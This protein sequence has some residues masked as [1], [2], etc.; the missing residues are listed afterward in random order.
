[1]NL[2]TLLAPLRS[3]PCGRPHFLPP[4][5]VEIGPG[6]LARTADILS[7]HGFPRALLAVADKNTLRAS[8]GILEILAAGGFACTLQLYDDLRVADMRDVKALLPMCEGVG[9]VLSIGSGSLNDICRLAAFRAGKPFA[10]F[11]TA[12]SM[13]GFA[14]DTAPITQR[15]FKTSVPCRA[16]SVIIGDTEV[17]AAA[18][19]VLKS[20]GFGDMLAKYVALVDWRVAQLTV[21]EYLCPQIVSLVEDAL[22]RVTSMAHRV[23]ANDPETAGAIMEALVMTGLAMT[24]AGCTRPASGCEHMISHFWEIKKL[25]RGELSDFHGRKVAVA[26]LLAAE[27]YHA[28]ASVEAMGFHADATDWDAVYAAYGP[29][30]ARD[31][32]ACNTP[33]VTDETTPAL[34]RERWP[35]I[36]KIVREGLPSSAELLALL[37]AAGAPT[38]P[39]EIGV[40]PELAAAGLA[41]H[42]YLRHR[43]TLSR[44]RGMMREATFFAAGNVY[45]PPPCANYP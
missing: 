21:G 5:A 19:A 35:E 16:P 32:R 11:A 43:M 2:Q 20:A 40:A 17:L 27:L 12:P 41:F 3:C 30:F 13:D 22:R 9:G 1:M 4:M 23:T 15:N 42:P 37:R 18:P 38:A 6:L 7:S 44:L 28:L 39:A 24:L 29:N 31:V 45:S 34:L 10:I 8:E 26:T 36:R 33:T 25:E 14:S